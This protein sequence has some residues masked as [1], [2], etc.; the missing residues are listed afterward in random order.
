MGNP[1]APQN[2]V[3]EAEG[4]ESVFEGYVF[5]NSIKNPETGNTFF[6]DSKK[7]EPQKGDDSISK[8]TK[9]SMLDMLKNKQEAIKMEQMMKDVTKFQ[10][11]YGGYLPDGDE[12]KIGK[13]TFGAA[14]VY[15]GMPTYNEGG[16]LPPGGDPN[17][18]PELLNQLGTAPGNFDFSMLQRNGFPAGAPTAQPETRFDQ[19]PN[20]FAGIPYNRQ[21]NMAPTS[22]GEPQ[23]PQP[24]AMDN[25]PATMIQRAMTPS[26]QRMASLPMT[27]NF[28]NRELA[29]P[30][31]YQATPSS[32]RQ[33]DVPDIQDPQVSLLRQILP[34]LG[35]AFNIG[36]G[37]SNRDYYQAERN[38]NAQQAR[39]M[40]AQALDFNVEDLIGA[41][42]RSRNRTDYN[43]K[44]MAT[45]RGGAINR[46]TAS[47][48]GLDTAM[49]QI[50][51]QAARFKSG[52]NLQ[53]ANQE[54]N[55]GEQDRQENRF[56]QDSRLRTDANA[57]NLVGTGL[58][59]IGTNA[60]LSGNENILA[61]LLG[62]S[63]GNFDI[64]AR[65]LGMN[66]NPD[67]A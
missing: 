15:G 21:F 24:P 25:Y 45:S 46:M 14:S 9:Q 53:R 27:N 55:L 22:A 8:K 6:K 61:A 67:E 48:S 36:R 43:A 11:K 5:S 20:F 63:Y 60:Q 52:V 42:T 34:N 26:P 37:L 12:V 35:A 65:I 57:R 38:P 41:A 58:G 49:Q 62:N 18:V 13:H 4:Q 40:A 39:N 16:N 54:L 56:A 23:R 50:L 1:T 59:Q 31:S 51:G 44:N 28:G 47:Q 7:Y 2:A 3:A 30:A 32:V 10:K 29:G 33:G 66:N 17:S 64:I 19:G